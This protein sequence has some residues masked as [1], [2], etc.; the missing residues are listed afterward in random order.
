MLGRG[1]DLTAGKTYGPEEFRAHAGFDDEDMISRQK[2]T[3]LD[4]AMVARK[5]VRVT[6]VTG[7]TVEGTLGDTALADT[8]TITGDASGSIDSGN[9][10]TVEIL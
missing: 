4:A 10:E 5:R 2:T 7:E 1:Y 6:L 9:V 3:L 8:F